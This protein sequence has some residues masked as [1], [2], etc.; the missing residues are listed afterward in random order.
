VARWTTEAGDAAAEA[1]MLAGE[2][3]A[4]ELAVALVGGPGFGGEGTGA[5][6]R[7]QE[8]LITASAGFAGEEIAS[9]LDVAADGAHGNVEHR[10]DGGGAIALAVEGGDALMPGGVVEVVEGDENGHEIVGCLRFGGGDILACLV[11]LGLA[12]TLDG[13]DALLL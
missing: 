6:D 11:V 8:E 4:L 1:V 9:I 3:L 5:F 12:R 13:H 2:N 7:A 10:G